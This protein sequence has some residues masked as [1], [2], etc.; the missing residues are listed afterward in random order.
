M[1]LEACAMLD[2]GR[3]QVST[4][5]RGGNDHPVRLIRRKQRIPQSVE[6]TLAH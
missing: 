4:A 3:S 6:V 5:Q 1:D 2:E